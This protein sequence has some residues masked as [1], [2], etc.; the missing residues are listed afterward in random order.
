MH[1]K[2][3]KDITGQRFGRLVVIRYSKTVSKNALW[4]CKCD[5]GKEIE[6]R[7]TKLRNGWTQSCGC[8]KN[9]R[10][11]ECKTKDITGEKYGMLTAIKLVGKNEKHQGLWEC[12]CDCGN[13]RIVPLPYL[14]SGGYTSCGCVTKQK[15]HDIFTRHG[16]SYTRLYNTWRNMKYRCL[17]QNAD[18]YANYGG[19][20]IKVCNEWI[21][22]YE[23]FRDWALLNGYSDDLTLDRKDND[24]DYEP[25]NCRWVSYIVQN[26]NRR[27]NILYK[28]NEDIFTLEELSRKEDKPTWV[29]Q[30]EHKNDYIGKRGIS[31]DK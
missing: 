12:V 13:H 16:D 2:N 23:T 17:N 14:T 6:V 22:S 20:G 5:C 9:D 21:D 18:C 3:F 7:G 24:G 25:S 31:N 10:T 27:D 28:V 11:S 19:R 8:Y 1:S 15:L 29:I 4:I 30:K 26:N